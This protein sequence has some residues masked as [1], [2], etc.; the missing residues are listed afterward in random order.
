MKWS[1]TKDK[2]WGGEA[3][4]LGKWVVA[5]AF[6]SSTSQSNPLKYE[7]RLFLP[8]LK[9]TLNRTATLEESKAAAERAVQYWVA[10]STMENEPSAN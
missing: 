9:E 7:A 6:Y 10:H 8:G 1:I 2:M 3:L 4:Y 5:R